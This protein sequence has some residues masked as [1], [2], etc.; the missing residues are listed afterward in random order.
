MQRPMSSYPSLYIVAWY[1]SPTVSSWDCHLRFKHPKLCSPCLLGSTHEAPS[2]WHNHMQSQTC[3]CSRALMRIQK[4]MNDT[5][6]HK[7]VQKLKILD[8]VLCVVCKDC[9]CP[10]VRSVWE[11]KFFLDPGWSASLAAS[12][13]FGSPD[14]AEALGHLMKLYWP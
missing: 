7:S 2:C 6:F 14:F 1:S 9:L 4:K 8:L 5:K 12:P 13:A 11:D 3:T 10:C